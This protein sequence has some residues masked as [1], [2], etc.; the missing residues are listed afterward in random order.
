MATNVKEP[1]AVAPASSQNS[2][3]K[4]ADSKTGGPLISHDKLKRLYSTMLACR[5][6]E[7]KAQGLRKTAR[8]KGRY[9]AAA[10]QEAAFV[11]AAIDLRPEDAVAPSHLDFIPNFI[12]GV[13]LNVL[14]SQINGRATGPGRF[15]AQNVY[16]ST[17]PTTLAAQLNLGNGIALANKMLKN[18]NIVVAFFATDSA[19]WTPLPGHVAGGT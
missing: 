19:S 6:L 14:F 2:S 9:Y 10:G 17:A 3:S 12:K 5:L 11:G 1:V 4:T 18:D 8:F 13:P 7:E 16:S 15:S